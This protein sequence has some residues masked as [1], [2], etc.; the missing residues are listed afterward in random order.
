MVGYIIGINKCKNED[1]IVRIITK[2]KVLSLYRFYGARHSTI[3]LGY[4]IDFALQ[5]ENVF[6]DRL[7]DILHLGNEWMKDYDKFFIWQEFIKLLNKHLFN[8]QD[9]DE[10]YFN[11]LS[12]IERKLIKQD[13][14]RAV[15]EAY[16]EILIAEGRLHSN[17]RC[18][19]CGKKIEDLVC[20]NRSFLCSCTQCSHKNSIPKTA[21]LDLFNHQKATL[22]SNE[23]CEVLY[24]TIKEGL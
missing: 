3:G 5:K 21:L 8:I 20:V 2:T 12:V 14:K 6:M 15:I 10:T 7:R 1:V 18:F 19:L 16:V 22:L 17:F 13:P 23:F 9:V 24:A 4:R 11:A